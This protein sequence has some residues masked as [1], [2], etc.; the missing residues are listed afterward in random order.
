[1]SYCRW[2]TD[3]FMCDLYCYEDVNGGWTTHV[4]ARRRVRRPT[5][6]SPYTLEAIRTA[7]PGGD[8][9][10]KTARAYH[11]ELASIPHENIGLPYDGQ[12]F[13]DDTLEDFRARLLMLREA[14]YQFPDSV[15][16]EV[17]AELAE[18]AA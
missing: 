3:D 1:M 8:T 15:L 17:D 4:A 5:S 16:E 12:S 10:A 18:G 13:N 2:S 7:K 11:D 6:P 14:G 9:W